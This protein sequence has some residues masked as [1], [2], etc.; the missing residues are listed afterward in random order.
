MSGYTLSIDIGTTTTVAALSRHTRTR[1]AEPRLLDAHG[2]PWPSGVY[3]HPD[4]GLVVGI[5][6]MRLARVDASRFE[7]H[8]KLHIDDGALQLGGASVP[9]IDVLTALIGGCVDRAARQHRGRRPAAL[10]L[11]YPAD[12][13]SLRRHVLRRA[14]LRLVP[15]VSLVAEPLAAAARAY[16]LGAVPPDAPIVVYDLGAGS[17]DVNAVGEVDGRPVVLAGGSRPDLGANAFDEV[18]LRL[19]LR[20]ARVDDPS[21]HCLAS[22]REDVGLARESLPVDDLDIPLPPP[23]TDVHLSGAELDAVLAPLLRSTVDVLVEVMATAGLTAPTVLL[24]GGASRMPRCAALIRERTGLEP[25]V[26]SRREGMVCLGALT[27][28]L[29]EP[30]GEAAEPD[31]PAAEPDPGP[32]GRGAAATA[33]DAVNGA[34][35]V[36][37]AG[38]QVEP[39]RSRW[40]R[41]LLSVIG[42]V[43]VLLAAGAVAIEQFLP[44]E[45]DP[46][47]AQQAQ[48]IVRDVVPLDQFDELSPPGEEPITEG[49]GS[50]AS[51]LLCA[52]GT[53]PAAAE[54][55]GRLAAAGTTLTEQLGQVRR[56]G[57][58]LDLGAVYLT[59]PAAGLIE[60][61]VRDG[62]A[63]CVRGGTG[64]LDG[65]RV[66]ADELD[67][68]PGRTWTAFTGRRSGGARPVLV[69]CIVEITG[70]IGLRSCA[71]TDQG[72]VATTLLAVRGLNAMYER[73]ADRG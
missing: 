4:R 20:R 7:P 6:A 46:V 40:R 9:I 53:T 45:G 10:V 66:L 2:H 25:V 31:A 63:A 27:P 19:V 8:P 69:T 55:G 15:K 22:L 56:F 60:R 12:W 71:T 29:V 23:L 16:A 52:E 24:A 43:A 17:L 35:S 61:Q 34:A 5:E 18:L 3:L 58:R 33:V 72:Q 67:V 37:V 26:L 36:G 54:V 59:E 73:V 32:A 13:G 44:G 41:W 39:R 47:T 51:S 42:M 68:P 49:F 21:S 38:G 50:D 1:W 30:A 28:G 64:G 70:R 65:L 48:G 57:Q 14:G 11:T 62:T